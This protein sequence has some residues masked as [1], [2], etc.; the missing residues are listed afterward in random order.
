MAYVIGSQ[1]GKDIAEKMQTGETY[2]A[3]D[4]STW[5]KQED[6][7]V[8][9]T[10]NGQTTNNAYSPTSSGTTTGGVTGT[11]TKTY[12]PTGTHNDS[13]LP[14]WAKTQIDYWKQQYDT[15]IK[16]GDREAANLA[17][18]QAELIRQ[19]FNYSGGLDGSGYIDLGYVVPDFAYT[20]A[21]PTQP[22]TDPRINELL[23]QILSREDFSYNVANDPL[24]Q[25]YRQMYQREGDRAM[26][27]TLAEA[28]S[29]AGGMNSY[30]ITAAQQ[31]NSYYNSQLNDKIPELYQLA[32]QMYLQDKDSMVQDLGLL[33]NMDATQ[34]SRYRDT[35]SDWYNDRN[36]AYGMYRDDV[37]DAQ[38]NKSFDN[39]AMNNSLNFSN[40]NYWA[41]KEFDANQSQLQI[42]NERYDKELELNISRYDKETAR[43]EVW[44]YIALGVTPSAELVAKAGMTDA[45]VAQAVQAV[46]AGQ[47]SSGGS[48]G[49]SRSSKSG[50][51]Y[52][53]DDEEVS[54]TGDGS[55]IERSGVATADSISVANSV[56]S[57]V[58]QGRE[59][60]ALAYLREAVN[61]GL[62]TFDQYTNMASQ[63]V[64]RWTQLTTKPSY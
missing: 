48:G 16:N 43:E 12:T 50:S 25:Q 54:G 49:G 24:Y 61:A 57:L 63:Y 7:S 23:N 30:A 11:A 2:T 35:M 34:Y 6:G 41:N 33:Q 20:E 31:A 13:T 55:W 28:A 29:G 17:H 58:S 62:I 26:K 21:R 51:G 45:E 1:K 5:T 53:D 56:Q 32:Y 40:N 10:H 60:D 8:S 37:G 39:N 47:S 15:A 27:E 9:V 14:D 52:I 36:F 44:K 19:N 42:E 59:S 64:L 38:W 22:Q 4:G 46:K 3:S 18:Q